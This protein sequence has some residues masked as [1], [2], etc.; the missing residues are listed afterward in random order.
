MT[1]HVFI[2]DAN[3]FKYHL[4]YQFA[5]TGAKEY[6]VD[7]LINPNINLPKKESSSEGI[8]V[9]M[10]AD[11]QRI[12]VGDLIIFY[13]QG[14]GFYGVFRVKQVPFLDNND[15]SQFLKTNLG[16]SLTFRTLIEPYQVYAEGVTEWE[17]LDEIKNVEFP[18]QMLWTLLQ[19]LLLRTLN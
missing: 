1:T 5:G 6:R 16:K 12:R 18:Y 9:E 4:E 19:T 17:A 11:S 8:L 15:E 14:G 2:V 10:I 3:T 7:F 13:L